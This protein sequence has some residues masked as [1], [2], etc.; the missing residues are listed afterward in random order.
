MVAAIISRSDKCL[1]CKI[2]MLICSWQQEK[3]FQPDRSAIKVDV[4]E[5]NLTCSIELL[6]E[7]CTGC[8]LCVKNC[9]AGALERAEEEPS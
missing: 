6:E 2:C 7:R 5:K 3:E 1:G 4:D 9:P 8:M